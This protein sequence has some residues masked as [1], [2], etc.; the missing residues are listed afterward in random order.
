M[1]EV[2]EPD[3]DEAPVVEVEPAEE[4]LLPEIT[5]PSLEELAR[6]VAAAHAEPEAEVEAPA[7][8]ESD[9]EVTVKSVETVSAIDLVMGG[10]PEDDSSDDAP[11][12]AA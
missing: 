5:S 9:E 7:D 12:P 6:D 2:E 10:A 8:E 4:E 11:E 3:A 1:A